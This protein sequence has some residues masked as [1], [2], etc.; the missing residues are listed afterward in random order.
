MKNNPVQASFY[1]IKDNPSKLE[2]ICSK[3]KEAIDQ[4][5]KLLILVGTLEAGQYIDAL[6]WRKPEESFI[7]HLFTQNSTNEWIAITMHQSNINQAPRV[8]NLQLNAISFFQEF[9][10]IIEL[11]DETTPEKIKF[12]KD[13]L[14]YYQSL[15][16]NVGYN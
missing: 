15:R 7:P 2:L 12:S 11:Y 9:E 10:E 3:A 16:V 6:L 14:K 4:E 5:K 1:R 8:L 13:R